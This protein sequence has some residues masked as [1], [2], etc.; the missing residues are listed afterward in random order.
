MIRILICDDEKI[1]A[2]KLYKTI[3]DYMEKSQLEYHIDVYYSGE[4]LQK[5]ECDI[6]Q[7]N[8]LFLDIEMNSVNGIDMAKHF[9]MNSCKSYIVFVTAFA[10][11]SIEGYS[12][13]TTRFILKNNPY[14]REAINESLSAILYKM[15]IDTE[16]YV[17]E[18]KQ[19][20]KKINLYNIVYIESMT[21]TLIFHI[22][23]NGVH[24]YTMRD[25]LSKY[26]ELFSD[27]GFIKVHQSYL[28]NCRYIDSIKNYIVKLKDGT[29]I[30]VSKQNYNEIKRV[31]IEY[32]GDL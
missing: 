15:K 5:R 9:R 28:V 23:D 10:K 21:H 2:D 13:D 24:E 6:Y 26:V 18:F 17:F 16:K 32:K 25:T 4:D 7:Y 27:K 8:I 3:K 14:L 1:Y 30:P 11:Y 31:Y 20:I 29:M 19:C 12:V 22:I